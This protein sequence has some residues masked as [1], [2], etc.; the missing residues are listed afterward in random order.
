MDPN[1]CPST[2]SLYIRS[3]PKS[4]QTSLA[5]STAERRVQTLAM[6]MQGVGL[7]NGNCMTLYLAN[8]CRLAT[9]ATGYRLRS[10]DA[11]IFPAIA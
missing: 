7:L 11:Q 4:P 9:D 6:L 1:R 3:Y 10:S 2:S 8:D 5:S